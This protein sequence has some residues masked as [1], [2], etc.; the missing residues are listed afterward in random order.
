MGRTSTA[1]KPLPLNLGP[2][3]I[4]RQ[5]GIEPGQVEVQNREE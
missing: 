4:F 5:L 1:N 3:P 2:K